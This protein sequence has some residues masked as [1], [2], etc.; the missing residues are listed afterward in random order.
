MLGRAKKAAPFTAEYDFHRD[1]ATYHRTTGDISRFVWARR[2]KGFRQ[3][4]RNYTLLFKGK[5][6]LYPF[7]IVLHDSSEEFEA[8]LD[9]QGIASLDEDRC[10]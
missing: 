5:K 10:R 4:R 1:S 8:Y 6:S 7:A 2:F 9:E 3:T